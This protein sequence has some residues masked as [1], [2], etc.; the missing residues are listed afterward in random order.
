MSFFYCV[1]MSLMMDRMVV[2]KVIIIARFILDAS[3]KIETCL[4]YLVVFLN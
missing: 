2:L 1:I 3:C 4:P